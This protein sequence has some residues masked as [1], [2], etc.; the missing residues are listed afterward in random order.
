MQLNQ[1]C[2][3]ENQNF[4]SFPKDFCCNIFLKLCNEMNT[5][6]KL[7]KGLRDTDLVKL[8]RRPEC[9]NYCFADRWR[10][11]VKTRVGTSWNL[12]NKN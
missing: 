9:K 7:T 4:I 6:E 1:I 10:C 3:S 12:L 5:Y 2:V 8:H 11:L